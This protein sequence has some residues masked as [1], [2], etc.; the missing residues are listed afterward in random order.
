MQASKLARERAAF[1]RD[2]LVL[3]HPRQ[4]WKQSKGISRELLAVLC[5]SD[6]GKAYSCQRLRALR[7]L[8]ERSIHT[9]T[10]IRLVPP[11]EADSSCQ[12]SCCVLG[13]DES[14]MRES[15]QTIIV[16]DTHAPVSTITLCLPSAAPAAEPVDR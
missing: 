5:S 10:S 11:V 2:R 13:R 12:T 16:H 15:T 4:N 9:G 3:T 14:Q 6:R 1:T 8:Q 7:T